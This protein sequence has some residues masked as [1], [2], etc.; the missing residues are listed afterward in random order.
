[1]SPAKEKDAFAMRRAYSDGD[2]AEA[3]LS[4]MSAAKQ[5]NAFAMK[6]ACSDVDNA[7]AKIFLIS[8]ARDAGAKWRRVPSSSSTGK[9]R[10]IGLKIDIFLLTFV[11]TVEDEDAYFTEAATPMSFST[12]MMFGRRGCKP[13]PLLIRSDDLVHFPCNEAVLQLGIY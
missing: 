2:D 8:S 11:V 1:M 5:K 13:N 9:E 4:L 12:S 3:K 6:H 10:K 7:E